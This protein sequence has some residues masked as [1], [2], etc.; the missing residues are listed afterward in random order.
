MQGK[1]YFNLSYR[2][3]YPKKDKSK[4]EFQNTSIPKIQRSVPLKT[5]DESPLGN[6]LIRLILCISIFSVIML[7][8]NSTNKNVFTAY[9]IIKEWSE[10]N[11]SLPEEYGLEKLLQ[12]IM[13]GDLSYVPAMK[14]PCNGAICVNYGEKNSN[15]GE[16]LGVMISSD[17]ACDIFSSIN[18]T[19][20]DVGSNAVIGNYITMEADDEVEIIYGCC[21]KIT[22][23][24]GD[25]VD[26]NTVMA[27]LSKGNDEKYYMYMEVH[28]NG[29]TVDPTLYFTGDGARA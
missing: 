23:F 14:F 18:G 22:V 17:T 1:R 4:E 6:F 15:G 9:N 2:P 8:K 29:R 10:C 27:Q 12:V 3:K 25:S 24:A 13:Y 16:C 26:T 20:T 28:V 5:E 7:M 19:V 11:Y 21:D